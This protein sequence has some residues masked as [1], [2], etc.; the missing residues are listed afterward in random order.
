VAAGHRHV[1]DFIGAG[2][3][4]AINKS[5]YL[6]AVYGMERMMG[7][8]ETPVRAVLDRK[9]GRMARPAATHATSSM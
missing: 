4:E 8:A 6:G 5:H 9:R 1:V 7:R 3:A 2:G